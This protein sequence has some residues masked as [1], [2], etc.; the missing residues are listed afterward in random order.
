MFDIDAFS[1]IGLRVLQK[2]FF[3]KQ[4]RHCGAKYCG[5]N[6]LFPSPP[7]RRCPQLTDWA[8]ERCHPDARRRHR[9]RLPRGPGGPL[10][11]CLDTSQSMEGPREQ[12][13]K[14]VRRVYRTKGTARVEGGGAKM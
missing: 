14:A 5:T 10:L 11:V 13:A 3:E 7:R 2:G 8:A 4:N 1:I 9:P 6:T 12:I